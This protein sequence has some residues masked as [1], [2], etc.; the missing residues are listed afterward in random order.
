MR[1]LAIRFL[2]FSALMCLLAGCSNGTSKVAVTPDQRSVDGDVAEEGGRVGG[3]GILPDDM[4][5]G[6]G[7]GEDWYVDP[8]A[9]QEEADGSAEVPMGTPCNS[10]TDCGN[11][12]CIEGPEGKMC[13]STCTEGCPPGW[14][15]KTILE[16]PDEQWMCV[17]EF[18]DLCKEC[19]DSDECG[20]DGDQCVEV[21]GEGAFCGI[22]CELDK[23]CP[24]GYACN[25]VTMVEG[26]KAKQCIPATGSC[27]C[28]AGN[29]GETR[30]CEIANQHGLCAG[31]KVCLGKEG[32]SPC[33]AL[34]PA[35]EVCDG[36]D[37]ECDG[38]AD[39]G[40][41]DEDL[42]DIANCVDPDDDN[43]G[44][45][46]EDDNCPLKHNPAQYD[47][48]KDGEGNACD[49]DDDGDGD[50]DEFD[51]YPL[52]DA[53]Y[54][55]AVETCD[56]VDNNCNGQV[57]EGYPD[58]DLDG[59][60]NCVDGDDDNDDDPDVTDCGI[61]NANV[62]HGAL[63]ACDGLDN[64]CNGK[65]DEGFPDKDGDGVADCVDVDTDGDGDPDLTDCAPFIAAIN[66]FA[67]EVCDGIDNN[68]NKQVD[69]GYPDFDKDGLANCI[70]NDDDNDGAAD[71][72]DCEPLD[73]ETYP[74]AVELCDGFDNNCNSKV[75]EGYPNFDGDGEVDCI[76]FDDDNDGD[77]DVVDCNPFNSKIF[78]DAEEVCDGQDNDC[79]NVV[80]QPG[81]VG[82][83]FF[84]KD[85]DDDGWGMNNKSLCICGPDGEY[86]A[87]QPGDCDD[88]TWAIN[89]DGTE[90]CNNQDDDCDGVK[91]NSGSLGCKNYYHDID[92]DGYGSGAA[93]CICW[94][95]DVA[96]T[97]NG[98]DCDE[99]NPSVNPGAPELC[100][101]KD[102]NCNKAIDEG[103]GSTCGNC[104][105]TCHEV[106]IGPDGTEDFSIDEENSSG[107]DVDENGFLTLNKEEVSLAFIWVANSGE[108]TVTKL[109]TITGKELGRY[110]ICSDPSRTSVDLYGDVWAGCRA[111]GGVAKIHVYEKNCI[112][113]NKDGTI[114]TSKDGNGDG[115]ISGG[116][117]L[118]K[119]QDE[120]VRFIAYPGGSCQ[121]AVGVDKEN[122]AWVGEWYG[123]VLRRCHPDDGHVVQSI[124]IP[125]NP[126]GLV[127]DKNGIIWVSGRGNGT[128]VRVD[129][130]SGATSSYKPNLGCFDP[131]GIN[132]DYKGRVW[133][134]N[135][136]CWHVGYRFDP[137]TG[138]W[139][140][141]G[142]TARPRGV[143]GAA[144][145][146][147]YIAN[148]QSD[149]V[150]V[151]DSDAA[152]T[153]AYVGLGGGRFPIG[154]A[155]DFDGY[156]WAVN[157]SSSSASKIDPA[158]NK[159]VLEHATGSNPYTYSDMT[160]YSLHTYTAPQG[161]YQ[162]VI[163]GS[164][165]GK[166]KWSSLEL[167][168]TTNGKSYVKIRLRAADTVA[169][170]G[171]VDFQGPYGPFPPNVFPMDLAAI[172]NL[173]GKY[174]QVEIIMVPDED[175][176]TPLLKGVTVQYHTVL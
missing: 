6:E 64:D 129:P 136:C 31:E 80:D 140:A 173:N 81:A 7:R 170:L 151:V 174:L 127:I 108:Q 13:T 149:Q 123:G 109:D 38:K 70:D 160:G 167:N 77:P 14:T 49:T 95:N 137:S 145:G 22:S 112:D 59:M 153:I 103:V 135:C 58:Y 61:L 176:N 53:A 115:K 79:N 94:P 90:V 156:I 131:Y 117:M 23:D 93:T 104:D 71:K 91:D 45:L 34:T 99:N 67:K 12:Y 8:E 52:D 85:K 122:H 163:P 30:Y 144:D 161:Y 159:V 132:L 130:K 142:M 154:M 101:G 155:V 171:Q 25:N 128:L 87:S 116:E 15:C 1:T 36:I 9:A 24:L 119:G 42:D 28:K 27:G 105:P 35:P 17:P 157:N 139:A 44:L 175:G 114:T 96:T 43:D 89:P 83:A 102:N 126:Y 39:D 18:F 92:G 50:P 73:A 120:C 54:H 125:T 41:P 113:K 10:N 19:S 55:G 141:A 110:N 169:T 150:A 121:R 16:G 60:V 11:G 107:V 138:Q 40:F 57:D 63:E 69:E 75:D 86:T 29:Q 26:G 65:T 165:T 98:G 33:N 152:Q 46:D 56:G 124:G 21:A 146:R 74:G 2:A 4:V 172:P 100:D 78:H 76:D 158:T 148:D 66:S 48:D 37:N 47:M 106:G 82:C 164:T 97:L 20:E 62:Y 147:V 51:C 111:D 5:G 3:D 166:T 162:H 133:I 32:W 134:A 84:Y 88:S 168:V 68:C 118:A 143:A 72:V